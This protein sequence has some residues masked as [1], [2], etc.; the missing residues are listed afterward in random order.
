MR[1]AI[2]LFFVLAI[3]GAAAGQSEIITEQLE[4]LKKPW[5]SL[6]ANDDNFQF[7]VVTDRTGGNRPG[8]FK[9]GVGKINL[10]QPEFVVSVGDLIQ[11]YTRDTAEL[12][13]QWREFNSIVG[14]FQMPFFYVAGNHD[15]TNEKMVELWNEKFGTAQY[16]FLYKNVLFLC[17]N[18]EDGATALKDP[19]IGDEQLAYAKSVLA[20]HPDVR[21]TMVFMHQPLW[22]RPSAENWRELEKELDKRK[23]SVFTGHVHRYTLYERNKSDYFT[24]ATMGGG[25]RLRGSNY[26]EFDHFMWVTMTDSGPYYANIM[27]DGIQDKSVY[28]EAQLARRQQLDAA[29]PVKLLPVFENG[30]AAGYIAFS[31]KNPD[32]VARKVKIQ[33]RSGDYMQAGEEVVERDIAPKGEMEVTV[34][35]TMIGQIDRMARPLTATVE[36]LGDDLGWS[37]NYRVFPTPKFSFK[38]APRRVKVDGELSEWKKWD[39]DFGEPGGR[40]RFSIRE[41]KDMLYFAAKVEDASIQT[42]FGK[43]H[44]DQDGIFLSIDPRPIEKSAY[45]PQDEEGVLRG[46]WLALLGQPNADE[47]GLAFAEIM[48]KTVQAKGKRTEDGYQV[49]FAVPMAT[50]EKMRGGKV[51]DLRINVS[52]IDSDEGQ[53]IRNYS[54]MPAWQEG[55]VGTGTFFRDK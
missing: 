31:V 27:L 55:Y 16:Y 23:H 42:G 19:D 18:S 21:W 28:T 24:L 38:K 47:F 41:G 46:E 34:P 6:E 1:F 30:E 50:L 20:Q 25:S 8:I 51:T 43:G 11:G 49:E 44:L 26:G 4:T 39:Y 29:P 9:T 53:K 22:I 10:I 15:Y 52:V 12:E 32:D 13:R 40:V 5:T 45:N 17:L 7:V 14:A 3:G 2:A 36:L 33:L 54:W 48:P 35:V 37:K